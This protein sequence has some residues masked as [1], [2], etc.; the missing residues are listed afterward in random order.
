MLVESEFGDIL[1]TIDD[2]IGRHSEAV[3]RKLVSSM[4]LMV[5]WKGILLTIL[6]PAR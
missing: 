5:E 3:S 4:E 2:E 6:T 1:L